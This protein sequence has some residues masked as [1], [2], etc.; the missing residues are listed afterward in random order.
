M[1]AVSPYMN[2]EV[3][4]KATQ[5]VKGTQV[6]ARASFLCSALLGAGLQ[7]VCVCVQSHALS[8]P[9]SRTQ[10]AQKPPAAGSQPGPGRKAPL[11][12]GGPPLASAAAEGSARPA[13]QG[14]GHPWPHSDPEGKRACP[15]SHRLLP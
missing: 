11:T 9:S 12:L 4:P 10:L 14:Q 13:L 2:E 15:R 3:E 5:L 6:D 1:G 7:E 8:D